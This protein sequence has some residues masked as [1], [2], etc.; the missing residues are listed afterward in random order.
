MADRPGVMVYFEVLDALDVLEDTD[1]G[2]LFEG[3]LRYGRDGEVPDFTGPLMAVWAL[4]KNRLDRDS[5]RYADR[6][7][8]ARA[9]V[10]KRWGNTDEYE[11]MR[12]IP[13]ATI[14]GTTTTTGTAAGTR[15][16]GD[17]GEKADKLSAP[18]RKAEKFIPPTVEEAAAY[19][20]ELG[21]TIDPQRFVDYYASRGWMLKG[22]IHMKDW[23]A[24]VRNW[25]QRDRQSAPPGTAHTVPDAGE[26]ER[27]KKLREKLKG[28]EA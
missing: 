17:G 14:T 18:A 20:R 11:R 27:M 6:C 9:A 19:I 28:G 13:T 24:E 7:E 2:R 16:W 3:I 23:R 15:T 22:N 25:E 8:K 26:L 10:N 5:Q 21:S 1:K 4:I 12:N